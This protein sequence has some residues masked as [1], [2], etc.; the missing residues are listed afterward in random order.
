M[1]SSDLGAL[2]LILVTLAGGGVGFLSGVFGVGG[3]FLLV[4]VLNILLNIRMD[5]AVGAGACQV[6][7]PATTSI[8]ARRIR[9]EHCRLPAT[10]AGGLFVGVFSGAMLFRVVKQYGSVE[11][12]GQSIPLADLVV[13][14]TYLVLLLSLGGFALWEA[15]YCRSH[16]NYWQGSVARWPIPPYAQFPEFGESPV[17][18]AIIAW[19]GLAVGFLGGLLGMSGG[20]VLLPG[21]VYL[22]GM[23]TH[24]AIHSSIVIV[25]MVAFQS[26]IA[27]SWQGNVDLTLVGALLL[28]GTIG[29]RLGSQYCERMKGWQL[30][31]SFGW[32]LL[33]TA[34]IIA[35]Q[36][37]RL[38][39]WYRFGD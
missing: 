20:L 11:V 17:S 16:P 6:L 2:D 28:G 30:R 19:F 35:A 39:G 22:L 33:F 23:Q 13:L 15:H 26:T 14:G 31:R 7:G 5:L 34:G 25:W 29:A 4:P 12:S 37:V 18:I 32:L 9:V 1:D 36:L 3:G 10:V 27:H 21:L 38:L 24:Q 8:L